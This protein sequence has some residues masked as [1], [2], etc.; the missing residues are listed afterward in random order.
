MRQ[1][2]GSFSQRLSGLKAMRQETG[3]PAAAIS[4][5]PLVSCC[6][7]WSRSSLAGACLAQPKRLVHSTITGTG[8][9][10]SIP[11]EREDVVG[12]DVAAGVAADVVV[13]VEEDAEFG[14]QSRGRP[15]STS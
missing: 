5:H 10:G 7:D 11:G 6:W 4:S 3:N 9:G 15:R 2:D 14:S 12:V 13:G 8:T 1:P